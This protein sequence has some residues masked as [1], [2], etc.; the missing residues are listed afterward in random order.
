MSSIDWRKCLE[1]CCERN[2]TRFDKETLNLKIILEEEENVL[3]EILRE[4]AKEKLTKEAKRQM[5]ERTLQH[6]NVAEVVINAEQEKI[7]NGQMEQ[8]QLLANNKATVLHVSA[9][10]SDPISDPVFPEMENVALLETETP[11]G[12]L[13]FC[14]EA[15]DCLL[16]FYSSQH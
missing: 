13:S 2:S 4:E 8:Q 1:K 12:R 3:K 16:H 14:E 6:F 9:A 10:S 7:L 15:G 11:S 5:N